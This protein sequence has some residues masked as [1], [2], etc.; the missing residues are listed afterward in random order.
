MFYSSGNRMAVVFKPLFICVAL[1]GLLLTL[2]AQGAQ[3]QV[4]REHLFEKIKQMR[5]EGKLADTNQLR[6]AI[7]LPLRNT[8][9]LS[10]LL[11]RIYDP[12]SP[13]YRHYLTPEQFTERFGPSKRDYLTLIAFAKANGLKVTATHPNRMLLDVS[14]SAMAVEKAMHVNLNVYRH[15]TEKRTFFAPDAEPSLDLSVPVL[16]ISGLDNYSLPRPRYRVKPLAA[17]NA[18]PNADTGSGPGGAYIGKDFRAAYVPDSSLNGSGQV[19][20]LLQFDGYNASDIEYYENLAGLPHVPLQNV[21]IDGATGDPSGAGGEVEVSLDIEMTIS[22]ATNL[23]K[24]I[25]Y[26]APN[27]RPFVD[28]LTQMAT[29]NEAKQLSCSWYLP[30]GS[31]D[32][33][34]DQIFQQM[35]AQGQSFFNASGDYG[36]Y[37]GLISFPGDTPYITQVGGTTLTMNSS[38]ESYNSET[39]WNWGYGVGS[40]GGISTQYGIPDYQ[41]NISMTANQGS[42]TMRNTPDVAMT[43]DNVYVRADGSDYINMGGTSCS[44][45]LWAGFAALVNQQAMASGKGPIGFINSAVDAIASS[46]DYNNCFHD[47]VDGD[48]TS[49]SSPT[50]YYAVSGYDLCTGWGT[51]K[52]QH[53]IDA[54]A[55]PEALVITPATG[56]TSSGGGGGPFT[57]TSQDFALTNIGTNSITWTLSNTSAWLGVSL[58]GGTLAAGKG[59]NVTISL[60]DAASNLVV[61]IYDATLEFT[62]VNDGLGQSRSFTLD[63]IAPPMI[64]VQPMNQA[65][66][67]GATASFTVSATGGLPLY[68]QWQFNGTNLTDDANISGSATTNLVVINVSSN[69]IGNYTV[70]VTNLVGS[71]ISSNAALTI[72]PSAPII[73]TQPMDQHAIVGQT[74][75]F[76]VTAIGTIPLYYQWSFDGTNITDATNSFLILNDVRLEQAGNYAV[77]ITNQINLVTSS[78]ALLT[79]TTCYPA[80]TNIVAW[81]PG[82]GNAN[83]IVGTNNGVLKNSAG[84]TNGIVGLAFD[85]HSSSDDYIQASNSPLW[86]FGS[87]N[88]TIEMWANFRT[89]YINSDVYYPEAILIGD[90]N[91]DGNQNKWWFAIDQGNFS[92]HVNS[93][94]LGPI[95]LSPA[96]FNPATNQWYHIAVVRNQDTFTFYANGVSVGSTN[97]HVIIPSPDQPLTIGQAEGFGYFNG[98]LDD[99]TIYS[100]ALSGSEIQSIFNAGSNGK[101]IPQNPPTIVIPPSSVTNGVGQTAVFGVLANGTTPLYYQWYF[102][103]TN[104]LVGSNGDHLTISNV[105]DTDAGDYSVVVTN[106]LGSVTSVVATLTVVDPPIITIQPINVTISAGDTATFSVTATG[107]LPLAYQWRKNGLNLGDG[108]NISGSTTANLAIGNASYS[109]GANYTVVITNYAGSVTSSVAILTVLAGPVILTQPISRTNFIGTS[110][111][112]AVTANGTPPLGYLWRKEEASLADGGNISGSTTATLNLANLVLTNSGN[113][114]V[115]ITNAYGSVLS[116]NAVLTVNPIP[117]CTP[118]STNVF[119]WWTAEGN[120]KDIIGTNNGTLKNGA[121]LTNG[122]VGQ[123]FNL[124]NSSSDYIQITNGAPLGFSSNN[125]TIELWVNFK[126]HNVNPNIYYPEAIFIA[127][128]NGGGNVNKWWFAIDQGSL[129]FHVN[130]GTLGPVF[131]SPAPFNPTVNQWYH[132]AVVRNINTFTFYVNGTNAGSINYSV[133]I[134]TP[135]QLITMGQAEN[136]GYFNGALDEVTIYRDALSA[137]EI[138]AIYNAGSGGK[139]PLPPTILV[140]PTNVTVAA[141]ATANFSITAA[142]VVP[143]YYQ[144]TF[145]GTNLLSATNAV[146][147]LTNVQFSQS[148][149]YA[150]AVA[151]EGGSIASSN[152]V[153]TVIP[154]HYSWN[155]IASPKLVNIPFAV[156]IYAKD[157]TNGIFTGYNGTVVLT[158]TN[159]VP[160]SPVISGNFNQGVWTGQV[161]IAQVGTNWVLKANDVYGKLGL[162]NPI[163]VVN[164]PSLTIVPSGITLYIFWP[165]SPSGFVLETSSDLT[166][167]NWIPIGAP[168]ILIGDQYLEPIT[169]AGTNAFYRLRFTGQ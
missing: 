19:V 169:I 168:P 11:Q 136:I 105:Q 24:V 1:I 139:C 59:T 101:C 98:W 40:G 119:A 68:Y 114:S 15:P 115:F 33:A 160:I 154:D 56:F 131:L 43:A 26:V 63:V 2:A 141:G 48:N 116:S 49:D 61:G 143:L 120:A 54:L 14:G 70:V 106:Y 27:S 76:S 9:E 58:N 146:L 82:E 17:T 77:T 110:A 96:P 29:D 41:T 12:S 111:T 150:V 32:S 85:L 91:G 39:V 87:G 164:L 148:G 138:Q 132:I 83:D 104:L 60:N 158:T 13:D 37:T 35:A 89:R 125:F 123:A 152:A 57:V 52:G 121:N 155:S 44:A 50:K 20:G 99:V 25:V 142:G 22:M 127:D 153:L 28:V 5:P 46:G 72:I 86:G 47:I 93:G 161:A 88:F 90:D 117:P 74:V 75:T 113:Y 79:I 167:G 53:L 149:V 133:V 92:F 69:D 66:I 166:S 10:N 126:T 6:L 80:P 95:F 23:S 42:T 124:H 45:P 134:P 157:A 144:W 73:I 128:D 137:S 94:S 31:A 151:N 51:P 129:S 122:I 165:V 65:V 4:V 21:L 107:T 8:V 130:S 102:N 118:V 135:S 62:N 103:G 112:F 18:L 3:R 162:A 7:A 81:W 97:Y 159:G 36:A 108:G 38:G 163:N 71:V 67:E 30:N 140:Q 156:A 100:N 109:D 55:N 64:M 16:Q 78:N 147:T 34:A 145:N 84:F